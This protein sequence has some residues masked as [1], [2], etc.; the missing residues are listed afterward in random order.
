M[1]VLRRDGAGRC[2]TPAPGRWRWPGWARGR[3]AA[4]AYGLFVV[5]L[6]A[7]A[8]ALWYTRRAEA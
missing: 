7:S 2:V 8:V 4:V 3:G 5:T 6:A 1:P